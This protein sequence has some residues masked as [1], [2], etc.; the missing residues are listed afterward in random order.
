M[1][2]SVLSCPNCSTPLPAAACN[3]ETE[4]PCPACETPVQAIAFPAL[5]QRIAPGATAQTIL[6]EGESSCYYHE[7]KRA[8]VPCETCGRFLCAVCDVQLGD[9]HFCP[10]CLDAARKQGKLAQLE[11]KRTLYDDAALSLAV[12]PVVLPVL[13][14]F[15]PVTAPMAIAVAIY[16]WSKPSS[17][18]PR[19]RF[20]AHL[21]IALGALQ[22][23]GWIVGII[24]FAPTMKE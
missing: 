19:T 7:H 1:N 12:W 9:Q 2:A 14:M 8:V 11:S 3:T 10:A 24:F 13:W 18:L 5:F 22:I 21:A 23:A 4:V 15:T 17:L 20:R 16:S 6:V